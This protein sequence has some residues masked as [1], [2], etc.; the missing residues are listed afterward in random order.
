MNLCKE[1][2]YG[3]GAYDATV[4]LRKT[5]LMEPLGLTVPPETIATEGKDF[6]LACF[7]PQDEVLA[8]LI[9]TPEPDSV[10]RMRQVAVA[11]RRQGEGIGRELVRFS[12]E[13]AR[14]RG[15]AVMTLH[16]RESA[17]PFYERL[18]YE[19]FGDLFTEVGIPHWKMRKG[20]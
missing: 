17:V 15:F 3:S 4:A 11:A 20:L 13:F 12:E 9:L 7:S 14:S 10:I 18:N 19:R 5:V 6:H 16:A 1:I 8:C 2:A